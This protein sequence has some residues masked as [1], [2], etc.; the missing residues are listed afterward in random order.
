M[1]KNCVIHF[2]GAPLNEADR[3]FNSNV[4]YAENILSCSTLDILS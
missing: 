1:I 4:S 3:A 2:I